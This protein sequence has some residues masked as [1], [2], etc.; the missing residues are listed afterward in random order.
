MKGVVDIGEVNLGL[1]DFGPGSRV[2][3]TGYACNVDRPVSSAEVAACSWPAAPVRGP[4]RQLTLASSGW[5]IGGQLP[6]RRC[7]H[8]PG[9]KQSIATVNYAALYWQNI[10]EGEP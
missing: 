1:Q 6:A 5:C 7:T 4:R 3:G 9:Q 10:R 2:R 8:T